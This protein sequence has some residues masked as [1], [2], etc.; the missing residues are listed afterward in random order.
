MSRL[1]RA[2]RAVALV[3]L[4][5][6]L[7]LASWMSRLPAV[8]REL[9]LSPGDLGLLLVALSAGTVLA[10][11]SSGPIVAR[12]GPARTVVTGAVL[13]SGG[14]VALG[15]AVALGSTPLAAAALFGYGAGTSSWDVAMNVEA[16]DVERRLGRAVMPRFH[17][18]FSVGTVLGALAGAAS[19]ALGI[20]LVSQLSVTAVAV[21][22]LATGAVP[23][24]LAPAAPS[25]SPGPDR[26]R[27]RE[28]LTAWRERRTVMIGLVVMAFA[29]AEGI[30]N[31][32]L[33]IALVDGLDA[34]PATGALGFAA[35]VSAM[36]VGRFVGGAVTDRLG[37]VRTL[38][39]TG[40]LA[41]VGVA[42]VVTA[43]SVP[44][45]LA[46]AL[47]WGL[48]ASLGFP[49]GMTAAGDD[50]AR[51]A[52]RVA[53]V[54]S[55]GYLAFLGGPPLLGAVGEVVGVQ[56]ALLVAVGAAGAGAVLAPA[57]R[58]LEVGAGAR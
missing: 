15:S 53:V 3:F 4:L 51:S 7:A 39:L 58:R 34:S 55:I 43:P 49:L 38:Q 57:V 8:R 13:T 56:T 52:A 54:S 37:R 45:A 31:D 6:G 20:P 42:L 11:P 25:A 36:T 48:G 41:A 27:A 30:A 29:L 28:A 47:L 22:L 26:P 21:L 10:L 19:A 18:G 12:L 24:F 32:W 17:A 44:V 2:K 5:N 35:F 1:E 23:R 40:G 50:P 14:M 16:A 9:D 33:A 46:G